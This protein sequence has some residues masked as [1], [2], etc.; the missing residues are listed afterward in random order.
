[1]KECTT[2]HDQHYSSEIT[3]K[4]PHPALHHCSWNNRNKHFQGKPGFV[5]PLGVV[6]L[7]LPI[8]EQCTY[9]KPHAPY[10]PTPASSNSQYCEG[11]T[12][13][14]E[15]WEPDIQVEQ[16]VQNYIEFPCKMELEICLDKSPK[17]ALQFMISYLRQR[18]PFITWTIRDDTHR[19]V[20]RFLTKIFS[21]YAQN[22]N[23]LEFTSAIL[24]GRYLHFLLSVSYSYN[25]YYFK[26]IIAKV[27][28]PVYL[29][30]QYEQDVLLHFKRMDEE[31]TDLTISLFTQIIETIPWYTFQ[32]F[33]GVEKNFTEDKKFRYKHYAS[34][35]SC[36][37][38]NKL[39]IPAHLSGT[40]SDAIKQ[41]TIEYKFRK[42]QEENLKNET[43]LSTSKIEDG[44]TKIIPNFQPD[45]CSLKYKN[46]C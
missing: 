41:E 14:L 16:C 25:I 23:D 6:K 15:K 36:R 33:E 37:I 45:N 39:E 12:I 2:P 24:I 19:S 7:C 1:M 20:N 35:E 3:S 4:Y 22:L 30:V 38:H 28:G 26:N 8:L 46:S 11:L 27:W 44:K 31:T 43:N 10:S 32:P 34:E 13:Y 17:K 5:D 18:G 9:A 21:G 29:N 40:M 42:I